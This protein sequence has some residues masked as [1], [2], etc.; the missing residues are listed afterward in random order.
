MSFCAS[1]NLYMPQAR[2]AALRAAWPEPWSQA[3]IYYTLWLLDPG[4][5][6]ALRWAAEFYQ[7]A[8]TRT[9][10]ITYRQRSLLAD[11]VDGVT[12]DVATS[13]RSQ[14]AMKA[15]AAEEPC[16]LLPGHDPDVPRRLEGRICMPGADEQAPQPTETKAERARYRQNPQRT[17]RARASRARPIRQDLVASDVA[18]Q[19]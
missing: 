17:A 13:L 16:I 15:L 9:P 10:D 1:A 19:P 4:A 12:Y 5:N 6:D 2:A 3:E 18:R 7:E 8:Y 14:R 11:A